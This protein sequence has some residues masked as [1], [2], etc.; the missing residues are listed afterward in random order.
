MNDNI[1][2]Q[3]SLDID[4]LSAI[5]CA[6]NGNIEEWVHNYLVQGYWA[7]HGLSDGLKLQKRWWAGPV[8]IK[9]TE[10][11]RVV[12]PEP[13]MEFITDEATWNISIDRIACNLQSLV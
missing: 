8:K 1:Y 4:S 10:L 9:L 5:K 13:D 2:N 7:N 11:S 3:A 6:R 12:G